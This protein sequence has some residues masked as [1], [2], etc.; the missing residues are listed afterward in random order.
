MGVTSEN[1]YVSI[2]ELFYPDPPAV[3]IRMSICV[4]C[5]SYVATDSTDL[6]DEWHARIGAALCSPTSNA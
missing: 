4:R 2:S 1:G 3:G 5:A 6:H